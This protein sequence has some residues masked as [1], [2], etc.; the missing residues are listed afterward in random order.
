MREVRPKEKAICFRTSCRQEELGLE[1]DSPGCQ[2]T[3]AGSLLQEFIEHPLPGSGMAGDTE[4][5]EE[6][7]VSCQPHYLEVDS[8]PPYRG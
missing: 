2:A 5:N 4:G 1:P 6:N 3:S 8:P 7:M